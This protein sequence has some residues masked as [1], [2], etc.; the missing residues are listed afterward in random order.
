MAE[1]C[2]RIRQAFITG[3]SKHHY[4]G[5]KRLSRGP[6]RSRKFTP[7]R[8]GDLR[9][10][11]PSEAAEMH[12]SRLADIFE[13]RHISPDISAIPHTPYDFNLLPPSLGEL[14]RA[15]PKKG[16][17][18]G[19]DGI[20]PEMLGLEEL[21][22]WVHSLLLQFWDGNSLPPTLRRA[23]IRMLRKQGKD[24]TL[25]DNYR[26]VCLL[27]CVYKAIEKAVYARIK[28]WITAVLGNNY[29]IGFRPA[30]QLSQHV[31]S[32]RTLSEQAKKRKH[33]LFGCFLDFKQAFDS[34]DRATLLSILE[35]LG[36]HPSL[37]RLIS[38]LIGSF[39]A[40]VNVD[41][42]HSDRFWT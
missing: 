4:L 16:R 11:C 38:G 37:T 14:A 35:K 25:C 28:G 6:V 19:P 9:S 29:Q 24:P 36:L 18:A 8:A 42:S 21:Q 20:T 23:E 39:E 27:S 12:A 30:Q 10:S 41:G 31:T 26:P 5:I 17:A 7:I 32:I 22:K 1:Q 33:D 40:F 13:R 2:T 34:C 3:D 15:L